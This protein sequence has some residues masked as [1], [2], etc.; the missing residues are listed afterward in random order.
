[1]PNLT[2][3]AQLISSSAT[4][5]SQVSTNTSSFLNTPLETPSWSTSDKEQESLQDKLNAIAYEIQMRSTSLYGLG[6]GVGNHLI[7]IAN[8]NNVTE[9]PTDDS[10]SESLWQR[11]KNWIYSF[12]NSPDE[13]EQEKSIDVSEKKNAKS[14]INQS[15]GTCIAQSDIVESQAVV[16]RAADLDDKTTNSNIDVAIFTQDD[17]AKIY[18]NGRARMLNRARNIENHYILNIHSG[19]TKPAE[20]CETL[21]TVNQFGPIKLL[22]LNGHGS[23]YSIQLGSTTDPYG[24]IYIN[25]YFTTNTNDELSLSC[26]DTY[27][28]KDAIIILESC[29]TAREHKHRLKD[30]SY[31]FHINMHNLIAM[32]APGRSVYAPDYDVWTSS[33]EIDFRS[34]V[35]VTGTGAD[36]T[37]FFEECSTIF[38]II[39]NKNCKGFQSL[40]KEAFKSA[41]PYFIGNGTLPIRPFKVVS[42]ENAPFCKEVLPYFRAKKYCDNIN[43]KPMAQAIQECEKDAICKQIKKHYKNKTKGI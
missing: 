38:Q 33:M 8:T 5:N 28:D 23:P 22:I 21:A 25:Q 17:I 1:M 29:S 6:Y 12:F 39:F 24:A 43:L 30:S 27:L 4:N 16:I 2:L 9:T 18:Y 3:N 31:S 15:Q 34:P 11:A 7:S 20:I 19:I 13:L 36:I 32:L 26:L 35:K 37:K 41:V 42:S 40:E 14:P 10:T